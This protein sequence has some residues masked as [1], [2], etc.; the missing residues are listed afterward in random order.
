MT[1]TNPS[2][3]RRI[4]ATHRQVNSPREP[5]NRSPAIHTV[6]S[7]PERPGVQIEIDDDD[8]A[9]FEGS[10][11]GARVR[12]R[13]RVDALRRA[14]KRTN[15]QRVAP[16]KN[17]QRRSTHDRIPPIPRTTIRLRSQPQPRIKSIPNHDPHIRQITRARPRSLPRRYFFNHDD[18]SPLS[19]CQADSGTTR[20]DGIGAEVEVGAGRGDRKSVV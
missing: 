13:H 3:P 5:S 1:Q 19:S 12:N 2:Y 10:A 4:P 9:V 18:P 17:N 6:P 16:T 11:S 15:C 7:E 20:T 14:K 8:F